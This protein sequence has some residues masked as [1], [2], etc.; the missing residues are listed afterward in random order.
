M[1]ECVGA[2]LL[3]SRSI[4]AQLELHDKALINPTQLRGWIAAALQ[5][6]VSMSSA[7]SSEEI[8]P[9]FS[10][11][12]AKNVEKGN[13]PPLVVSNGL[14]MFSSPEQ[15][16][17]E[18]KAKEAEKGKGKKHDDDTLA[19]ETVDQATTQPAKKEFDAIDRN[20]DGK[21]DLGE[22]SASTRADSRVA[23]YRFNCSDANLDHSLDLE[24]FTDA[25]SKP[26]ELEK[27]LSMMMAFR[28]VDKDRNGEISQDE[29]WANV[30]GPSFDSRWAFMVACSD[31]NQDRKISPMEF[32]SDMY[33]CVEEKENQALKGFANFSHS[34]SNGDGCADEAEMGLAINRLFGMQLISDRPPNQA[35][36][37]LTRRWMSCVD[38][39]SNRCLNKEEYMNLLDPSPVQSRCIGTSYERYEADMDFTIMDTN[40]DNQVSQQEYYNYCDKLDIEIEQQEADALFKSADTNKN[41]FIDEHEFVTAGD[42]Y[43]GDGPGKLFFLRSTDPARSLKSRTAWA[44]S[45]KKTWSGLFQQRGALPQGNTSNGQQ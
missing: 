8:E 14:S 39:D 33:G 27:C 4:P 29:L 34:D 21:I 20:G 28:L 16:P 40:H 37:A 36:R 44:G 42:E 25:Q 6:V 32:S 30:G 13:A 15:K 5:P 38:F 19:T 11:K 41:G 9:K 22:Y 23:K 31:L 24:E 26:K 10:K 1:L 17:S 45:L 43:S 7:T 35:M 12:E 2:S 18:K 3:R